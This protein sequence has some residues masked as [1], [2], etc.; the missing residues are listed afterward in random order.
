MYRNY[1]SIEAEVAADL[2][3]SKGGVPETAEGR[4]VITPF[5]SGVGIGVGFMAD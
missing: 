1:N 3:T 4:G 5:F 2:N